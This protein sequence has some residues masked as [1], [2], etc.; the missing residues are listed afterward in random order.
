MSRREADLI[1]FVQEAIDRATRHQSKLSEE[2]LRLP[3]MSAP[4]NRHLLNNLCSLPDTVYLEIGTWKGSTLLS[5]LFGN[6]TTVRRA[7]AVENWAEFGGPR[8]EF[9]KNV[10]TILD[11]TSHLAILQQDCFSVNPRAIT[12]KVTVYFYDGDHSSES[13]YEAFAHYRDVFDSPLVCL[14]DDWNWSRVREGTAAALED[15]GFA[16]LHAWE[17]PARGNGDTDLWW[18]G[19]YVAVLRPWERAKP[20]PPQERPG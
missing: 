11:D 7:Y 1:A 6:R 12:E 9:D 16:V 18:N 10:R 8:E 20:C 14:V 4:K 19:L 15:L 3:G 13:H 17:L 5:A 2:V